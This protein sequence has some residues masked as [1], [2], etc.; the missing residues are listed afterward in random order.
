MR[1]QLVKKEDRECQAA[2]RRKAVSE[3][4]PQVLRET[5]RGQTGTVEAK[6]RAVAEAA[7]NEFPTAGIDVMLRE[8]GAGQCPE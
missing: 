3:W 7:R 2:R 5:G 6:L 4:F 1:V 8:I